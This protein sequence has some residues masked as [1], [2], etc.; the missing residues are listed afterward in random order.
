MIPNITDKIPQTMTMIQLVFISIGLPRNEM[1]HFS[2]TR[3]K[4]MMAG[5]AKSPENQL[6]QQPQLHFSDILPPVL[7][8]VPRFLGSKI[9]KFLGD[10]GNYSWLEFLSRAAWDNFIAQ[11]FGPHMEQKLDGPSLC[12]GFIVE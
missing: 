7:K 11:Y 12:E 3:I 1:S 2:S 10:G 8:N 5:A 6:K 4:F 9:P